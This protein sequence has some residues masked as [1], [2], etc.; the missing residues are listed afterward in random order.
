MTHE[1]IAAA[2]DPSPSPSLAGLLRN[3]LEPLLQVEGFAAAAVA[4]RDGLVIQHLFKGKGDAAP[5]CAMAAVLVG[6]SLATAEE[7]EQGGLVDAVIRCEVG[8]FLVMEAGPEALLACLFRPEV[9]LGLAM[10]TGARVAARVANAL[11]EM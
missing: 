6:A 4:R 9:N 11:A 7:L 5:L 8:V 3:D 2:V 1:A 10:L